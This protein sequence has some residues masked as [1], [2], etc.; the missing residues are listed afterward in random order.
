MGLWFCLCCC[1]LCKGRGVFVACGFL[2]SCMG[3]E[4]R[5]EE[6]EEERRGREILSV[7]ARVGQ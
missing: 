7:Y 4:R 6:K 1:D 5:G 2:L 3:E